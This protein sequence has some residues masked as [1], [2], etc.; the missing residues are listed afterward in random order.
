MYYTK[1]AYIKP[2]YTKETL[3]RWAEQQ[4]KHKEFAKE[5]TNETTKIYEVNGF[6]VEC[7]QR[8][9]DACMKKENEYGIRVW[10]KNPKEVE[11]EEVYDACLTNDWFNN[12]EEANEHFK[13][14]KEML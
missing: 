4:R 2:N 7:I 12:A 6:F 11:V 9:Y 14:T 5:H 8:K 3:D 13:T 10:T 1:R